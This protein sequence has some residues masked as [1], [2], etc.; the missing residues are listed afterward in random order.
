M[1]LTDLI[2]KI[3]KLTF[4]NEVFITANIAMENPQ[5]ALYVLEDEI[6]QLK[7]IYSEVKDQFNQCF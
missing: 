3:K 5:E 6:R 4:L 1:D 2:Y 7:T